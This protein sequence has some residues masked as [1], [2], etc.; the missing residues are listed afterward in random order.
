MRDYRRTITIQD[1]KELV[2]DTAGVQPGVACHRIGK[3]YCE[4]MQT[5]GECT[6]HCENCRVRL[7]SVFAR[8]GTKGDRV[9]DPVAILVWSCRTEVAE[10]DEQG[11]AKRAH[12]TTDWLGQPTNENI[13]SLFEK[14]L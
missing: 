2:S 13:F 6:N 1:L 9:A 14:T 11:E 5:R 8:V 12:A 7:R 3:H 4:P 10:Y